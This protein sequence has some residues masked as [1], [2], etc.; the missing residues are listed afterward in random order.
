MVR[1]GLDPV[2]IPDLTGSSVAPTMHLAQLLSQ[3]NSLLQQQ[4][5]N[6]GSLFD[7]NNFSSHSYYSPKFANLCQNTSNWI[8]DSGV[9]YH[10]T[11]DQTKLQDFKKVR[12]PQHVNV[13]NENK[14]Q[15]CGFGT[16]NFFTKDVKNILCLPD[17]NSNLLSVGKITNDL[18]CNVIFSPNKV[19][20]QDR[21]SGEKIGKENLKNG[22]YY[23][24]DNINK[25]FASVS[26]INC[27]KLLHWKF[28]HPS[29]QVL[30][31]LFCHNLDSSIVMFVS[32]QNKQDYFSLYLQ[33]YQINVLI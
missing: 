16:T 31:K 2:P 24:E 22:L 20:F 15:I 6:P 17:F 9:T 21:V 8:I 18:N 5:S 29:D 27:D 19:I 11:W 13:A 7:K 28:G 32:L 14:V 10:M 23:L 4:N 26:P 1:T 30:N 33:V 3:L 12:D 25:C